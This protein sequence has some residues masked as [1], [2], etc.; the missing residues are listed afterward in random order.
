VD[1]RHIQEFKELTGKIRPRRDLALIGG[2][3]HSATSRVTGWEG[4]LRQGL[5][6]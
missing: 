2:K 1:N 4:G 3:A 6:E 5:V